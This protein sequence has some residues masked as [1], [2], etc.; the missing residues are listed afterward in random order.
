MKF[1]HLSDLHLGK[2]LNEHSLLEDQ[3][4]ILSQIVAAVADEKPHAVLMAGD[5]YDKPV[6]PAEAVTLF[7]RFLNELAALEPMP[8]IFIISGNHDSAERL[9]FAARLI[10]RCG[11]HIATAFPGESRPVLLR[12][13]H[14]EAAIHLL[15][16][17]RL[18][19]VRRA[20]PDDAIG[21]YTAA[22]RA[23]VACLHPDPQRRN[24]LVSHQF[25]TGGERS[26]SE[27]T[28][29][30]GLDN[31]DAEAYDG[32]D[33]VALGHLHRPQAVPGHPRLRYCGTPLKYSFSEA[34]DAKS[35][36]VVELD[37]RGELDVR[38]LPLAP[39]HDLRE[40]CGTYEELTLRENYIQTTTDDY[41]HVILTDE[42]DV[43]D[44]MGRLRTIYPNILKLSYR[45]T[46]TLHAAELPDSETTRR[47]DDLELLDELYQAQN[48]IPLDEDQ[49]S[50]AREL[51]ASLQEGR[52]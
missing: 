44:A 51:F 2:R 33:Y 25:V 18:S 32:F 21:D 22:I 24:I 5:I 30:G 38:T 29:I 40:I 45:N 9:A 34:G 35:L 4:A 20:R 8:H 31:V 14:G 46:R 50:F 12:D 42:N 36:L 48:G 1:I 7:D 43:P 16:F 17:L 49:R 52:P 11:I 37:G 13:E 28:P 26:D 23:A 41:L 10:E 3:Q 47:R 6:P 15:P 39:L 27:E 19:D